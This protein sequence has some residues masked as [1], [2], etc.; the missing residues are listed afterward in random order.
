MAEHRLGLCAGTVRQEIQ[1]RGYVMRASEDN[2]GVG[3]KE[4]MLIRKIEH[5]GHRRW[6]ELL[7][8]YDCD[9]RYHPGKVNVVADALSKKERE[10]PLR[11]QALVLG[12]LAGSYL[13]KFECSWTKERKPEKIIKNEDVGGKI[14]L[15]LLNIRGTLRTETLEPRTDG[16]LCSMAGV[17]PCYGDL[18]TVIMQSPQ[19]ESIL[20]IQVPR[21]CIKT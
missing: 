7:S 4:I 10:P 18:R 1:A 14:G 12:T 15:K 8:D 21:K 5:E 20:S 3:K 19:I 9:I 17:V 11:V 13:S 16:T 2:I 6:L